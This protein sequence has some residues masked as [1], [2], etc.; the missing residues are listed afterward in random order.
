LIDRNEETA[1]PVPIGQTTENHWGMSWRDYFAGQALASLVEPDDVQYL[2]GNPTRLA[3]VASVAYQL[4]D[5]MDTKR[6]RKE[7]KQ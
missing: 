1:L 6:K 5:A 2:H 7:A 4:A 3:L